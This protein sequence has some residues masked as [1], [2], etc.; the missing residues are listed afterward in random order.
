MTTLS[1]IGWA[2]WLVLLLCTYPREFYPKFS[3]EKDYQHLVL[4]S[5]VVLFLLWSLRAGL[6]DGLQV[7]FLAMTVLTLSHGWRIAIWISILPGLLLAVFGLVAWQDLGLVNL[8]GVVAPAL[9]SYGIFLLSYRYLP[10]HLFVYIFVAA[11]FNGAISQVVHMLLTGSWIWLEGEY[12]WQ[13]IVDNYLLLI[14]LLLFPEA[15]LNGMATTLLVVYKPEWVR[16]FADR[17]YIY[18]QDK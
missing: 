11:F 4:G 13:Y 8:T 6:V 12:R 18:R 1:W 16:T 10:R 3:Q 14:P 15:L 2:V 7:H 5:A 9:V 17:D